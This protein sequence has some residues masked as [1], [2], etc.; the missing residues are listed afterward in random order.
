MTTCPESD[1]DLRNYVDSL[2]ANWPPLREDQIQRVRDLFEPVDDFAE[3]FT[4][5]M[6]RK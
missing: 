4:K 5:S 6:S 2:V 1:Q 3:D